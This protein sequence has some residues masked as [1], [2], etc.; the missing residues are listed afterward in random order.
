MKTGIIIFLS[1][2]TTILT[3]QNYS[4]DALMYSRGFVPGTARS[5]GVAGAFGAVGADLSSVGINPAGL[6]LYRSG[7]ASVTP[8]FSIT[9]NRADY[10]GAPDMSP[11][12]RFYFGQAG[13][14]WAIPVNASKPANQMSFSANRLKFVT[15]A[16]NYS[17]QSMFNRKVAYENINPNTSTINEYANYV[18][19]TRFPSA[20]Y[21]MDIILGLRT[22]LID[23]D[24]I[25]DEY[26]SNM[27]GPVRQLGSIE[28]RGA[29]D[30]IDISFG[31]NVNDKLYLGAGLGVS[32]MNYYQTAWYGED[33]LVDSLS[34][35]QYYTYSSDLRI[36]GLGANFNI[37]FLYRPAPW[38]RF[39]LAYHMPTFYNLDDNY[40]LTLDIATDSFQVFDEAYNQFK[41]KYR[42]PMKGVFSAAFFIKQHAFIS[43]DYE[44]LNYGGNRFNFGSDN[45]GFS[46]NENSFMKAN[47]AYGHNIRAGVEGA[48]KVMRVRAGYAMSTSPF[49][50][51]FNTLGYNQTRHFATAGLGYRG[52]RFYADVAYV[53]SLTK[54]IITTQATD[55]I[56]NT[57]NQHQ[58]LI[59]L[60]FRFGRS[61]TN[62]GNTN[63]TDQQ[64]VDRSF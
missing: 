42:T 64:P 35:V 50:K 27:P 46:D 26:Y 28:R 51:N 62:T 10:M 61:S 34:V 36:R 8:A 13:V 38:V 11:S 45:T 58:L 59:T 18:D 47:Y 19:A 39:G 63:Y 6:A 1:V 33:R 17:R 48:I 7:D 54:D 43:V 21:G 25:A 23:Y 52:N 31:F 30:N 55:Y 32:I 49:N 20:E 41:Y 16:V 53:Y 57:F 4:T 40:S 12:S 44:F 5:A 15:V 22:R 29:K 3:A 9:N 24:T 14:V 2:V 60:G 56:K 37:G